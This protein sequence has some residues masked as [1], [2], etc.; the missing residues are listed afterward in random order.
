M[1]WLARLDFLIPGDFLS[2]Y[3]VNLNVFLLFTLLPSNETTEQRANRPVY[4]LRLHNFPRFRSTDNTCDVV[5]AK[6]SLIYT[7]L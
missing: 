1:L 5:N 6:S 3:L 7:M 4:Q 2:K